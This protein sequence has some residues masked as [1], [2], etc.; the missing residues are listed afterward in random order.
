MNKNKNQNKIPN[1]HF[2][3]DSGLSWKTLTYKLPNNLISGDHIKN[4]VEL[5]N[6]NV[7]DKLDDDDYILISFRVKTSV[8]LYRTI[9]TNQRI[10]KKDQILLNEIFSEFWALKA[11]NYIQDEITEILF[12]FKTIPKAHNIKSS[13]IN[14]PTPKVRA[15]L[16]KFGTYKF[17]TTMDIF[18]WGDV[19]FF[20]GDKEARV[21]K[22][23][24]KAI[25][26]INF[27]SNSQMKVSYTM[28]DKILVEFTDELLD[29]ANLGSFERKFDN[30]RF[31]FNDGKLVYKEK[32]YN[33][34]KITQRAPIPFIRNKIICMDLETVNED[35]VLIPYA[36]AYYDGKNG[37][38]FYTTDYSSPKD[39]LTACIKSLMIRK[40]H[41]YKIYLHN[42]SKFDAIFLFVILAELS[43]K[44]SPVINDG[45]LLDIKFGFCDGKY[46]LNFRDSLFM[47]PSS[48]KKLSKSFNIENKKTIFP[49]RF[50]S[51]E[52]ILNKYSGS[53]PRFYL[54]DGISQE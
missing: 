49:Y 21:L 5:F 11:D 4:S 24:S 16:L 6:Q 12:C 29:I 27:I 43:N 18:E 28:E 54:F 15:N 2:D 14:R 8:G 41:G 3:L 30:Q 31:I 44:L 50:A 1:V 7:L 23:H 17:P 20:P 35:G 42:F 48:L 52:N 22:N 33:F 34:S 25:Y 32:Y 9:S 46:K 39:M 36:V 40:Y 10:C 37:K 45:K 53:I 51:R 38:T 47:L 26:N 19:Q 13:K